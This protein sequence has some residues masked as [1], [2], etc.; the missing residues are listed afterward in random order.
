MQDEH[1]DA[2]EENE[3]VHESSKRWCKV[4]VCASSYAAKWFLCKHLDQTHV[5][6]MQLSRSECPPIH[7]KGLKQ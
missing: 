2:M 3:W 1:G 6:Q 4:N 7:P 5:L